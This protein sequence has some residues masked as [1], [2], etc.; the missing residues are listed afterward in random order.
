MITAPACAWAVFFIGSRMT[1]MIEIPAEMKE[2]AY[3]YYV[4]HRSISLSAIATFLGV[5]RTTFVRL[6]QAWNWPPRKETIASAGPDAQ[7]K[8]KKS[9][10]E[11]SAASTRSVPGRSNLRE[12]AMSLVQVTRSRIDA[13]VKE[14]NSK[15]PMDHDKAARTLASFAKT[16]TTAQ[17]LLEQEST[18]LDATEHDETP[19]RSIHELR[20]E[21]ARHLERIVAEEEA[22]GSDCLLV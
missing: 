14:Q 16:L 9:A 15:R 3:D 19:P 6:R 20:D 5:S 21:L 18:R 13:L 4:H 10:D 12:A 2:R 7:A 8:E 11:F 1:L 22:Q 17:A